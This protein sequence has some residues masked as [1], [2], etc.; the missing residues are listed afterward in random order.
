MVGLLLGCAAQ[1]RFIR[2]PCL[3]RQILLSIVS[4]HCHMKI[5]IDASQNW[6]QRVRLV[7]PRLWYVLVC[8]IACSDSLS[9]IAAAHA[10][11]SYS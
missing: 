9:D 10:L 4:F 1:L 8:V 6:W 2:L 11:L 5:N 7:V 3:I